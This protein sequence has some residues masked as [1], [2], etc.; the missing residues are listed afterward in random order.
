MM[1]VV[2]QDRNH[3]AAEYLT[4]LGSLGDELQI[5]MRAI[6][7]NAL[8]QFEDSV[9][10][11]QRLSAR[12]VVLADELSIPLNADP[13]TP[14]TPIDGDLMQQI[15]VAGDSL[16][17]LNRGYAALLQHSSRSTAMMVSL[18]ASIRGQFQEA[19][20]PRLKYQTWSCQM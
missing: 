5:A 15:H 6:A 11:Q 10:H 7:D 2:A 1:T 20:G 3:K 9:A 4:V 16:Q 14:V 17:K 12:L 13:A 18:F 8:S 19:S